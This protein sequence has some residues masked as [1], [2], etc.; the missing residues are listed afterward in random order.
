MD[1]SLN[2]HSVQTLDT[3][4]N[5]SI[6]PVYCKQ[7]K[8]SSHPQRHP[9]DMVIELSELFQLPAPIAAVKCE[10]TIHERILLYKAMQWL[11]MQP[12]PLPKFENLSMLRSVLL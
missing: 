5:V 4:L 12:K 3:P 10:L 1:E 2:L 9:L 8:D 6:I 11:T 7:T